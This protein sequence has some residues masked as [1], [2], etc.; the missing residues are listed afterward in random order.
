MEELCPLCGR[1]LGRRREKHHLVPK[2]YGGREV[3]VLHPICHRKIH[4]TLADREIATGYASIEALRTHPE[5]T[6][7]VAWLAGKPPDFY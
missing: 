2:R 7:F 3:A 1:P 5:I 6:R 4:K